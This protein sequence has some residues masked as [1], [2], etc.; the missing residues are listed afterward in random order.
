[1]AVSTITD[2][3]DQPGYNMYA[4]LEALLLK[5]ARRDDFTQEIEQVVSVYEDDINPTLET[6]LEIL[7][8]SFEADQA[9]AEEAPSSSTKQTVTPGIHDVIKYLQTLS[10]GQRL[11]LDQVCRVGR[12]LLVMPATNAASER[13]FS[14]MR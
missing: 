5:A 1:M 10:A 14:S 7:V 9:T 6:Q 11:L 3:F 4:T 2:R 8:T 12:L 13:S